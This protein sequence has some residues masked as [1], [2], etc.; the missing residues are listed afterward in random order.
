[1]KSR[2]L[3]AAVALMATLSVASAQT[4]DRVRIGVLTDMTGPFSD[5]VG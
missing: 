2:F 1:M 3:V 4:V 5:Q